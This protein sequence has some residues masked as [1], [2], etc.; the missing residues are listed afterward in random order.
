[1]KLKLACS[2]LP[3]TFAKWNEHKAIRQGAAMA[4]FGMFAI[5]PV[6]II[7]IAIAG[8]VYG[9]AAAEGNIARSI[10]GVVGSS[11]AQFVQELVENASQPGAGVIAAVVG[12]A[13]IFLG[14]AGLFFQLKDALNMV[15][16]VAPKPGYR[17]VDMLWDNVLSFAMVLGLGVLMLV[18]LLL[19]TGVS[20]VSSLLGSAVPG[21]E[22]I[23]RLADFGLS[24]GLVTLLFAGIFKFLPD[25]RIPWGEVWA[26]AI[27]TALL[28]TVVQVALG[29]IIRLANPG[30][31]FGAAGAL[32][33]ILVWVNLVSLILL[34][35][36]E[37]IRV[38]SMRF[39][40][41]ALPKEYAEALT[42]E[43]R[44]AQGVPA[45]PFALKGDFAAGERTEPPST[46]ASALAAGEHALPP[47]PEIP[48][49]RE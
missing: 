19:T 25:V 47:V 21:G 41:R 31:A 43:A 14:S 3:D 37:F 10:S 48:V 9:Q 1:M 17:L 40:S 6:L 18:S 7:A 44:T 15:W 11:A 12:V 34:F 32:V 2:A 24:F 46:E 38:T 28:L 33:V 42:A 39:G 22:T 45:K 30:L 29:V 16:E 4:Y 26:G 8:L 20:A 23:W 35:G 36:A 5:A 27:L 49:H 13:G